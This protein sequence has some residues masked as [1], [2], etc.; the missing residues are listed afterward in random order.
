[1][2]GPTTWS[3][4]VERVPVAG[5]RAFVPE[6]D[7]PRLASMRAAFRAGMRPGRE[8]PPILVKRDRVL[9]GKHRVFV[10]RERGMREIAAI[11][12]EG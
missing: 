7:S 6:D 10:A 3:F 12:I 9:D 2:T 8:L 5:L 1:M 11:M 4:P